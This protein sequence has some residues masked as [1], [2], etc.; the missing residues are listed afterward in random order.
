LPSDSGVYER[1]TLGRCWCHH[2]RPWP[3]RL[4]KLV[5]DIE[6]IVDGLPD[7]LDDEDADSFVLNA[8]SQALRALPMAR[9][10]MWTVCRRALR[11]SVRGKVRE[12]WGKRLWY[13][14]MHC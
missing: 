8:T 2:H 3:V 9:N 7:Q 1:R 6:V 11:K 10:A 13:M 4:G 5:S 14:C 12:A